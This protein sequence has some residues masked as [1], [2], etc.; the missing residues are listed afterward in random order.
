MCYINFIT[1]FSQM[2]YP[3]PTIFKFVTFNKNAGEKSPAK[4]YFFIRFKVFGSIVLQSNTT[5]IP[6]STA[7][8]SI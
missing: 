7:F 1:F 3:F 6:V 5:K 2:Q 4:S 8:G